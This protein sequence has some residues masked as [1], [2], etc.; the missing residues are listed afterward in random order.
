MSEVKINVATVTSIYVD[1][2][3]YVAASG[4]VVPTPPVDPPPVDP[5][6]PP[7]VGG[8]PVVILPPGQK[9][10]VGLTPP[11]YSYSPLPPVAP[12]ISGKIN[13]VGQL[14]WTPEPPVTFEACFS[15]SI[16]DFAP[17][18]GRYFTS[19]FPDGFSMR[20]IV[21]PVFS[22]GTPNGRGGMTGAVDIH[23]AESAAAAGYA[24]TPASE[25]PWYLNLRWSPS[26]CTYKM[27]DGKC[28][29]AL[30]YFLEVF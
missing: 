16:G 24:W 7:V 12:K 25:G 22:A 27:A 19:T 6:A 29:M 4:P 3:Q 26:V 13:L 15:R 23:D 5:P 18:P 11:E 1:G 14:V 2:V 20:F 28:G 17:T 8:I 30:E 9:V 10:F 21:A